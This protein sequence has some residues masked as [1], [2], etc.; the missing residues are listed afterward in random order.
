MT[1][2][3]RRVLLP[4][5]GIAIAIGVWWAVAVSDIDD[6]T[7]TPAPCSSARWSTDSAER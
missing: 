6:L 1:V 7:P 4:V 2:T 5:L 3:V